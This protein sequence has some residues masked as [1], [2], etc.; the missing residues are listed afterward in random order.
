M[1]AWIH[2]RAKRLEPEMKKQYG[3]EKGKQ[4]AFAT[5]TLM[6]HR[7]GKSPKTYTSKVT[8]EK[9]SF[10]TRKA[11]ELAKRKYDQPRKEYQKT[12]MDQGSLSMADALELMRKFDARATMEKEAAAKVPK[13]EAKRAKELLKKLV[14]QSAGGV[15]PLNPGSGIKGM[16][17]KQRMM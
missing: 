1:P 15:N 6:S 17:T 8:G 5:A 2:D 13:L 3:E 14:G 9:E 12:A 16:L 4:V 7:L 10:G 11:R